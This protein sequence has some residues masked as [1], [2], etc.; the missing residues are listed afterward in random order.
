[1]TTIEQRL[2]Q[3][4]ESAF[5]E[6]MLAGRAAVMAALE[7]G[8]AAASSAPAARPKPAMTPVRATSSASKRRTASELTALSEQLYEVIAAHPG[9][10]IIAL[11]AHMGTSGT[12][13]QRAVARLRDAERIRTVGVRQQMRYFPRA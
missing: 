3:Q 6:Y 7:R 8:L 9:E 5:S 2:Q 4:I 12:Q 10:G 11:S 13:L 1:M